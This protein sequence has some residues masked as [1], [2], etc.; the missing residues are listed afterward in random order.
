MR[1]GLD[2]IPRLHQVL[3][4]AVL[5][6]GCTWGP[7]LLHPSGFAMAA[8]LLLGMAE[9]ALGLGDVQVLGTVAHVAHIFAVRRVLPGR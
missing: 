8:G 1:C 4:R 5:E 7:K 9:G 3:K 6:D 2:A